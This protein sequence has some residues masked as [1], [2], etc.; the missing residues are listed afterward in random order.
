MASLPRTL[1][2]LVIIAGFA[3]A[4]LW[5]YKSLTAAITQNSS[6]DASGLMLGLLI[7]ALVGYAILLAIPFMPGVEV[8]IALLVME[9]AAIAPFIYLAT[10][11]GLLLAFLFGHLMSLDWLHRIFHDLHLIRACKLIARI[12]SETPDDRLNNMTKRLPAWLARIVVDWRYVTIGLL[13]NIP[14]SI[15]IGGG[16]GILML[17]GISRLFRPGWMALT[18]ALAVLPVPLGVWLLDIDLT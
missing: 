3:A 15:A 6:N 14:G 7:V 5:G 4:A 10:V 2:R 11:L 9:G 16:G 1:L 8:G 13:I 12:K 17:A 18:I